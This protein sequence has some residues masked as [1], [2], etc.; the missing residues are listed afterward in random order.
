MISSRNNNVVGKI[1][2]ILSG[3]GGFT[4]K[5]NFAVDIAS[6]PWDP[7]FAKPAPTR[8]GMLTILASN[9]EPFSLKN[10]VRLCMSFGCTPDSEDKKVWA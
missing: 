9:T 7:T 3:R 5:T 6:N 10:R 8:I 2:F 1:G 4:G